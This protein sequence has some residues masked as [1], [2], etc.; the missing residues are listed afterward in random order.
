[1]DRIA[2]FNVSALAVEKKRDV[3]VVVCRER[4]K[5]AHNTARHLLINRFTD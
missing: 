2:R 1:M 4:Q 3:V 5:L